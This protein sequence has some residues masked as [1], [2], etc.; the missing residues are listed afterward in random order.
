MKLPTGL[1][2]MEAA[3]SFR[4][5]RVTPSRRMVFSRRVAPV[6]PSST[7]ERGPRSTTLRCSRLGDIG[8][9]SIAHRERFVAQAP[10]GRERETGRHSRE[11]TVTTIP[12]ALHFPI[13][14]GPDRRK[15]YRYRRH[16]GEIDIGNMPTATPICPLTVDRSSTGEK[17]STRCSRHF[18]ESIE[19]DWRLDLPLRRAGNCSAKLH[20]FRAIGDGA[21]KRI[22]EDI[23]R[24]PRPMSD[25]NRDQS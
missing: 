2:S 14:T 21:Y 3:R 19:F 10:D 20:I 16:S 5:F 11:K 6:R 13:E 15:Q 17:W 9:G 18:R 12:D 25:G 4:R 8:K 24:G 23:G 7:L 1:P 22:F